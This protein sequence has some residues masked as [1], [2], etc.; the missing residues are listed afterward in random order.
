LRGGHFVTILS[1][2][3]RTDA[4]SV[5]G[6][7]DKAFALPRLGGM[8]RPNGIVIVSERY[9]AF[10]GTDGSV[11]EGR[12]PHPPELLHRIPLVRGL[13]RLAA[14][15]SPL[16]RRTGVAG[17]RER[18]LLI[19]ALVA[20]LLFFVLPASLRTPFGIALSLI[21]IASLL[22][23]RTLY[24]HGAEH[25]AIGAA[26]ERSLGATWRGQ[27]KPSR[28]S[29]RC[30]TNF[31]ALVLPVTLAAD[32]LWPLSPALYTPIAVTVLSLALTME[33]WRFVQASSGRVAKLFLL[34]GLAL[35]RVTTR[36]PTLDETR[37]ALVAVAAVLTRELP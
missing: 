9:W 24:L 13:A 29:P 1:G 8:A 30:G 3:T 11:K 17:A 22:R 7:A 26:E 21:L 10:A 35:Q 15:L 5:L 12:M 4:L 34:P 27:A 31:A 18:R 14:S 20:P 2:M 16:F 36:E 25:R 19:A 23:G 28:F 37:L 32:R 33:V 6:R